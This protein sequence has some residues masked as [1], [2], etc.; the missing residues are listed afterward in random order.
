MSSS[1]IAP[2]GRRGRTKST[3]LVPARA[4]RIIRA[5]SWWWASAPFLLFTPAIAYAMGLPDLR[6]EIGWV[7][8][9]MALFTAV[10]APAAGFVVARVGDRREA[11]GRFLILAVMSG[12][13]LSFLFHGVL[14]PE[15][16]DG[17]R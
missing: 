14:F 9:L 2:Q 6:Q 8:G 5:L 12:G 10:L 1:E 3:G 4:D 13:I 17:S 11:R 7:F 15:C 16:P